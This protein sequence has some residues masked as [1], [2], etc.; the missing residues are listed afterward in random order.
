MPIE[1]HSLLISID[2]LLNEKML[3]IRGQSV[4]L[5]SDVAE[6]LQIT[7]PYLHK[8]VRENRTR[9]PEQFMFKT[10]PDELRKIIPLSLK[11]KK[12]Y[13]FTWGGIMMAAGQIRTKRADE[14][15]VQLIR[16]YGKG[17][18][19]ELLEKSLRTYS[20]RS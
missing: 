12:I 17:I 16:R 7:I 18:G 4:L 14:I 6:L 3:T 20:D 8:K 10:S 13:V 5:D 9:F 1:N 11:R 2:S 15:S 19:F